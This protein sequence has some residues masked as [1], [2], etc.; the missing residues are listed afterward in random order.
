MIAISS[1]IPSATPSPL[2]RSRL[3]LQIAIAV[4]GLVPVGAGLAGVLEGPSMAGQHGVDA[5]LDSHFAYLS[6]LLLAIGLAFWSAIPAIERRGALVR[7]LTFL[8]TVG[9]LGRVVSYWRAGAPDGAMQAALV[10]EWV[11]TPAICLWQW[12]LQRRM[13]GAARAV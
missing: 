5:S 11:I 6:G 4:G 3:P 8:V 7:L 1:Q 2:F 9:G 12:R 13:D 10:M